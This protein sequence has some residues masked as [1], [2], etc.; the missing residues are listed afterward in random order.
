M[1]KRQLDEQEKEMTNKGVEVI[2]T[3]LK[4]LEE[5]KEFNE[6]TI[7]FQKIQ[8]EYQDSIRPFVV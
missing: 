8:V 7:A 5:Q 6:K 4:G 1:V 3:Q 2:E